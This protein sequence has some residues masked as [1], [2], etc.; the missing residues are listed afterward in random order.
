MKTCDGSALYKVLLKISMSLSTNGMAYRK[1]YLSRG[2]R[3]YGAGA[4]V[5]N[6]E[7]RVVRLHR[8]VALQD[9]KIC[10]VAAS[11]DPG[12]LG[13]HDEHANVFGR[14]PKPCECCPRH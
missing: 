1:L 10:R 4:P 9:K 12:N 11:G 14:R 2:L 6:R 8:A 7:I 13:I 5:Q 3:N